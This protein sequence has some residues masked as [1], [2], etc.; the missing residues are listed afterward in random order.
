MTGNRHGIRNGWFFYP[1]VFDPG[2]KTKLCSNY[3]EIS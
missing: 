2:W 1:M 3:K